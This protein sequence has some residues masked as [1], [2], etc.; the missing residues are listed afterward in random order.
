MTLHPLT[1]KGGAFV[2]KL[3]SVF[4]AKGTPLGVPFA[5]KKRWVSRYTRPFFGEGKSTREEK[6]KAKNGRTVAEGRTSEFRISPSP[7]KNNRQPDAKKTPFGGESFCFRTV[8]RWVS[9]YLQ[10]FST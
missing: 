7:P 9:V 6:R 3:G 8:T 10:K 1:S 2:S 5:L 4:K